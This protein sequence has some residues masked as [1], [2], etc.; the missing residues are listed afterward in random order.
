MTTESFHD[1]WGWYTT[2]PAFSH[3]PA[4]PPPVHTTSEV[5]IPEPIGIVLDADGFPLMEQPPQPEPYTVVTEHPWVAPVE[6]E[7][8]PNWTGLEWIELPYVKPPEDLAP[9]P[10]PPPPVRTLTKLAYMNRFTDSELAT[11]YTVA[12]TAVQV[13]IWL[14]KFKAATEVNL[15]DPVTIAGLDALEAAGLIGPGRSAEIRA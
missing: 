15:D 3:R 5:V 14:E 7:P 9:P 11:I 12:K 10:P 8:W 13:E 6:G 1:N 2:D 4:P